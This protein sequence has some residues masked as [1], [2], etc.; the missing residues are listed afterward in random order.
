MGIRKGVTMSAA[1]MNIRG[2]NE[3]QKRKSRARAGFVSMDQLR[4]DIDRGVEYFN[5]SFRGRRKTAW[6]SLA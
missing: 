3:A 5:K 1:K 2:V 6:R 4:K